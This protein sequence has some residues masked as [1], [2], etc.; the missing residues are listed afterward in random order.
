MTRDHQAFIDQMTLEEKASLMSGA[1]F[2]NTKAIERLGIPSFMLTD[3]PHGLRKQGGS[4]DHLGL[5]NSVPATC[6]PTASMLANTWD[7][8]LLEE[9]GKALGT[10]AKAEGVSVL[11]GPG[12]NIKRNPLAGRNFEYFS[13]DPLLAGKLAAALIR[14]IQSEGVAASLKHFA[15]NSQEKHRMSIDEVVDERALHETYLEGFRIAVQEGNPHT[16]MSSYNRLEG[17]YANENEEL[18]MNI[19]RGRWG[20]EGLVVT[21]WGGNNDR[22]A[23][24]KAGNALE[25]PASGGISDAEIVAA[26]KAGE[27]SEDLLDDRVEEVLTLID[28]TST[29]NPHHPRFE[30]VEVDFDRHHSLAVRAA[31]EGVVLLKNE[32]RLPLVPGTKVAVIG[33]FAGFLRIQGAGSSRVNPT[34]EISPLDALTQ[35]GLE[36]IGYEPGYKRHGGISKAKLRRALQLASEADNIILFVGLDESLEAEALDRPHMRIPREQLR[37]IHALLAEGHR[38][39]VVLVGGSPMELPFADHVDAIMAGYLSGQGGATAIARVITGAV[40]PSGKLA[41]TYPIRYEDVPSSTTYTKTEAA[42]LHSESIFIGYRYFDKVGEEVRYPFGHGLS[43]TRFTYGSLEVHK[44]GVT[45]SVSNTGKSA[46]SE[47]VQ[48]YAAPEHHEDFVAR[49]HLVGFARVHLEPGEQAELNIPFSQHAFSAFDVISDDWK[50]RGG[51]YEIRVGAS[52]RD[53]RLCADHVVPGEE[54]PLCKDPGAIPAYISGQ[55]HGVTDEEFEVLMNRELPETF[56]TGQEPFDRESIIAQTVGRGGLAGAIGG[57]VKLAERFFN[58]IGKPMWANNTN[59][60]LDMPLR[61]LPRLSDGAFSEASLDGLIDMLNG[62]TWSG[63]RTFISGFSD[64]TQDAR[65]N[66]GT[67]K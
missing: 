58:A 50:V 14:G 9:I 24:I 61:A 42:S 51:C 38:P 4:A 3:G 46:G 49:Q 6:F 53:I 32:D 16:V 19:L 66:T 47:T 7:P 55:V 30:P 63:L 41:E 40:N 29:A 33:D 11:L 10:E 39:I 26:V 17:I 22:V 54:F 27:L 64:T 34:R 21:D 48:V 8:A 12:N 43:Y 25:M 35:A 31:E 18:L 67:T 28:L 23:A 52:S 57:S 44:D 13:E 15:V 20:F 45:V 5:H 2:W 62:S 36:V 37:L 60:V 1:N 65:D 56:W 59:F